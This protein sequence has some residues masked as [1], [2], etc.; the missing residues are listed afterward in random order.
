MINC[1]CD[2]VGMLANSGLLGNMFGTLPNNPNGLH[3]GV[4]ESRIA[5]KLSQALDGVLE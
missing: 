2:F 5:G 3:A 1:M 4:G